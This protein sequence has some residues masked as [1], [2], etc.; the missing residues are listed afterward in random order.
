MYVQAL[1]FGRSGCSGCG[2]RG[3]GSFGIG[4]GDIATAL[5]PCALMIARP[6]DAA[7]CVWNQIQ[8]LI[9]ASPEAEI[10]LGFVQDN[11][12]ST[13][14]STLG[15]S[16]EVSTIVCGLG[17]SIWTR[18]QRKAY[19]QLYTIMRARGTYRSVAEGGG[20]SLVDAA[21]GVVAYE[22]SESLTVD[23]YH[24]IVPPDERCPSEEEAGG[25]VVTDIRV[26]YPRQL[27]PMRLTPGVIAGIVV[28][29]HGL[30]VAGATIRVGSLRNPPVATTGENGRFEVTTTPQA[31]ASVYV[32]AAGYTDASV[33]DIALAAG[34]RVDTGEIR[35]AETGAEEGV[36]EDEEKREEAPAWYESP[37]VWVA[38]LALVGAVGYGAYRYTK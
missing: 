5:T 20:R 12:C 24:D 15:L 25:P 9:M 35:L 30:P 17:G 33:R 7:I 4:A 32:S 29:A 21:G 6:E 23:G 28:D 13:V 11:D 8:G 27:A 18:I 38:G 14:M 1:S 3:L 37:W 19:E 16:S 10:L 22:C 2:T 36:V 26:L 31:H 34:G